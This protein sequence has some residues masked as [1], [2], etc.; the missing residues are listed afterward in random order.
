[1]RRVKAAILLILVVLASMALSARWAL[2]VPILQSPDETSQLDYVLS[3]YTK[4]GLLR[5][6]EKPVAAVTRVDPVVPMVHPSAWYLAARDGLQVMRFHPEARVPA[7]YGTGPYLEELEQDAPQYIAPPL[8]NPFYVDKNPF[9]YYGLAGAWMSAMSSINRGTVFLFFATR[10][11]SVL[12]LGVGLV[13]TYLA[14]R[15]AAFP[16]WRALAF[17]A[18]IGLFPLTSFVS[19]YVQPDNFSLA[20]LALCFL[21]AM[22]L[23]RT[24]N[25]ASPSG[26]WLGAGLATGALL[27]TKYHLF[28]STAPVLL[29]VLVTMEL[30]RPRGERRW[31]RNSALVAIPV[32]CFGALQFL[33][34]GGM[35][36][37]YHVEEAMRW[38]AT[39]HWPAS[40]LSQIALAAHDFYAERT[41]RTFWGHY[42]WVD[43]PL[44]IYSANST[45]LAWRALAIGTRIVMA[46]A[47]LAMCWSA[48]RLLRVGWSGRWARAA[49]LAANDIFLLALLSYTGMM[50]VLFMTTPV[51]GEGQGRHWYALLP[52]I[53]WLGTGV[54]PRVVR[55]RRGRSVIAWLTLGTLLLYDAVAG[56]SALRTISMRYYGVPNAPG[57]DAGWLV[58][59]VGS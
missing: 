10:F 39:N 53:F 51:A 12:L 17:T 58:R 47:L 55:N 52:A 27:I 48:Y 25:K 35:T 16:P 20:I 41:F 23:R 8:R 37:K 3:V 5:V 46:L 11:L 9:G 44:A 15:E 32:I 22:R 4:G 26:A 19:S 24:G 34:V 1:M 7:G 18:A 2:L 49:Q 59:Q 30:G 14:V 43:T 28:A 21:M 36:T 42:G 31:L 6:A 56:V 38:Q 57:V 33:Y 29:I 54:A 50:F 13:I 40:R 45:E